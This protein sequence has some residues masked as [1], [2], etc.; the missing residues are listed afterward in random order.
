MLNATLNAT[1]N[2]AILQANG[3]QEAQSV[4]GVL[5]AV[6]SVNAT[7]AEAVTRAANATG[8]GAGGASF[9]WT[10]YIQAI[11]MLCLLLAALYGILWAVRRFGLAGR[12]KSF[13][14]GDMHVEGQLMLGPKRSVM[15]VRI[16]NRRL[17]LG[18]TDHNINLLTELKDHHDD[19]ENGFAAVLQ[20]T[21]DN[22]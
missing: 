20:D 10:G 3:T 17:V 18:V 12:G 2:A 14:P 22:S 11:G 4:R 21:Q 1:G 15:V 7:A 5:D 16:L 9:D 6:S 19:A 8:L 13:R